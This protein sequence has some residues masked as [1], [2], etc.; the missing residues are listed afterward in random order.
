MLE[1]VDVGLAGDIRDCTERR[2]K[3]PVDSVCDFDL[4]H[5]L[6]YRT[7]TM[8]REVQSC[9]DAGTS[10]ASEVLEAGW[11]VLSTSGGDFGADERAAYVIL[12]IAH[13]S[14]LGHSLD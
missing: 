12:M 4:D 7:V 6:E 9:R 5:G 8:V 2:S 14:L 3:A 1:L 11:D 10:V 13:F